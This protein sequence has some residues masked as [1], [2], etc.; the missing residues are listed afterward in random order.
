MKIGSEGQ[1]LLGMDIEALM[2]PYV[3]IRRGE[4]FDPSV[5]MKING[6]PHVMAR[7]AM[8]TRTSVEASQTRPTALVTETASSLPSAPESGLALSPKPGLA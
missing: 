4:V 5:T 6:K 7:V 2:G 8:A 3:R 1:P